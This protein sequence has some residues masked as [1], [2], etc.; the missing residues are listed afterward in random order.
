M[1]T[2]IRKEEMMEKLFGSVQQREDMQLVNMNLSGPRNHQFSTLYKIIT[3]YDFN[4]DPTDS[5]NYSRTDEMVMYMDQISTTYKSC[6][7]WTQGLFLS[8][9]Q[10]CHRKFTHK[11]RFCPLIPRNIREIKCIII[12]YRISP[13]ISNYLRNTNSFPHSEHK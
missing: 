2:Q 6:N 7:A 11:P 8:K 5:D 3:H 10:S 9:N 1:D 13:V 12:G 4:S